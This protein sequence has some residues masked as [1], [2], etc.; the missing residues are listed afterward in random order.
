MCGDGRPTRHRLSNALRAS[1]ISAN[2]NVPAVHER[3]ASASCSTQPSIPWSASG[4]ITADLVVAA[5]ERWEPVVS[6]DLCTVKKYTQSSD[7]CSYTIYTQY[8]SIILS[9]LVAYTVG[10]PRSTDG[11]RSQDQRGPGASLRPL[12]PHL[13]SH[14]PLAGC[15]TR[16]ALRL[17]IHGTAEK[18]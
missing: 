18:S 7:Q 14:M 4:F 3:E 13:T 10:I 12:T 8:S 6:C 16:R 17:P 11:C 9:F 1:T 5:R 2:Q 15:R